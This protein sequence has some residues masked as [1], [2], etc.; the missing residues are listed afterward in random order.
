[1]INPEDYLQTA[2]DAAEAAG[3][4]LREQFSVNAGVVSELGRDIKTQADVAA[5]AII[6]DRLKPTAIPILAEESGLS[7]VE[8]GSTV[9]ECVL[10]E[11]PIWIV[12]PLDG[13]YNFVRG[14]PCCC[15]SIALWQHGKP[16]LGVIYDFGQEECWVG[17]PGKGA[18]CN[19]APVQVSEGTDPSQGLLATGFPSA[20]HWDE[21]S[22]S[23]Y[24]DWIRS[25]KKVRMIGSAAMA[26]VYVARGWADAYGENGSWVWDIAAGAALIEAAGGRVKLN[27]LMPNGQL[28]V[29]AGN[30][31]MPLDG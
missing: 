17:I 30:G 27:K 13:T 11:D 24:W 22:I 2:T 25:F 28:D 29:R 31:R 3:S 8:A 5:E 7:T 20:S 18:T 12:D 23:E 19:G 16:L 1:M 9:Q 14:I 26:M 6:L 10:G 15:V 21:A 4:V